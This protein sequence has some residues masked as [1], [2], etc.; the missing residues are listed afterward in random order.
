MTY[1]CRIQH[2]NLRTTC[3]YGPEADGRLKQRSPLAM[4]YHHEGYVRPSIY[5]KE[6]R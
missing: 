4:D 5:L 6:S 1:H 3:F 2:R